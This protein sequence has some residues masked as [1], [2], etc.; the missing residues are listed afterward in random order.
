MQFLKYFFKIIY[1]E[2]FRRYNRW[3]KSAILKGAIPINEKKG[4]PALILQIRSYFSSLTRAELQV[5]TYIADHPEEVIHQSVSDLA[6][7]SRTSEATVI[8]TCKKLGF[9]SYQEFKVLLAQAVVSPTQTISGN[10][11]TCGSTA[12]IIDH[13]FNN[14]VQT[15]QLTRE[16]VKPDDIERAADCLLQANR[17]FI[18]GMGNSASVCQDIQHKLIRLGMMAVAQSDGHIQRIMVT[19]VADQNDVVFAISHSGSSKE[20]VDTTSLARNKGCKIIT[21]TSHGKSPL[22]AQ[23]DI[24]LYTL[25]NE[26][27]YSFAAVTSRIAQITV[28][29][30]LHTVISFKNKDSAVEHIQMVNKNMSNLK[31]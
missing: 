17:I 15:L 8:R 19:S 10:I 20:L 22:A 14:T 7:G 30:A 24:C 16:I 25:S 4:V 13:V 28:I 31:Y 18:F 11:E 27:Q 21:L 3:Y 23:G 5:A 26:T 12:Q 9:E 6:E 2:I 29:D 1:I